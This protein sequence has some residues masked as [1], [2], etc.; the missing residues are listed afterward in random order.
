MIISQKTFGF[1]FSTTIAFIMSL[2]MSFFM[3]CIHLG[4]INGFLLIW[5]KSA[6]VA[7]SISLPTATIA[8]PMIQK[9]ML[10]LFEIRS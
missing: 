1:I 3:L 8:M 5:G 7:F 2:L 6:A 9:K 4:F 10:M